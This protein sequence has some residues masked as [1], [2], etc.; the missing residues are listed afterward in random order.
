MWRKRLQFAC[1]SVDQRCE[2]PIQVC[3]RLVSSKY[4]TYPTYALVRR[5]RTQMDISI[6]SVWAET[7]CACAEEQ[8]LQNKEKPQLDAGNRASNRKRNC[9]LWH[10]RLVLQQ[11]RIIYNN[12]CCYSVKS[13]WIYDVCSGITRCQDSCTERCED[14]IT[15]AGAVGGRRSMIAD[16]SL[17]TTHMYAT[18]FNLNQRSVTKTQ[19][20]DNV[21]VF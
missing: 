1:S 10:R 4:S 19:T 6:S 7:R 3:S 5:I 13:D 9:A 21:P 15:C 2:E 20:R 14:W 18:Y 8:K 12:F 16:R 11:L 17:R